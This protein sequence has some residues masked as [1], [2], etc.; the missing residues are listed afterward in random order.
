[1]DILI[2]ILI[3]LCCYIVSYKIAK[4]SVTFWKNVLYNTILL[5]LSLIFIL[6]TGINETALLSYILVCIFTL[7]GIVMRIIAP[8]ALNF[9]SAILSKITKQPC[10]KEN[11]DQ[12][13]Q[14]DHIFMCVVLF[15][16]VKVL[17]YVALFLSLFNLI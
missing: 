1:M 13:L 2:I 6:L 4:K 7:L 11:Y 5:L 14:D 15:T 3:F 8:R 17:L 9:I 16:S 10:Q 12:L